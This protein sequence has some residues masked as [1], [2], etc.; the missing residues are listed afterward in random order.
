M[1]ATDPL[2][3]IHRVIATSI[4]AEGVYPH[5]CLSRRG[6]HVTMMSLALD[7]PEQVYLTVLAHVLKEKPDAL[8]FGLGRWCEP[9]QGTTLGDVITG[10]YLVREGVLRWTPFVIEYQ[11]EPRVVKPIDWMNNF[12]NEKIRSDLRNMGLME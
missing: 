9:G 8:V 5:Q 11:H 1:P 2:Y 6:E 3:K 4:D 7:T 12:W 10:A